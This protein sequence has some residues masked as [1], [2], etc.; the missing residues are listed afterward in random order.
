LALVGWA[1]NL[2]D[3][4]VVWF[5]RCGKKNGSGRETIVSSNLSAWPHIQK[6]FSSALNSPFRGSQE[7]M[8]FPP[9]QQKGTIKTT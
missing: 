7:A 2:R 5:N 1:A 8:P 9:V 3:A 6:M 4:V